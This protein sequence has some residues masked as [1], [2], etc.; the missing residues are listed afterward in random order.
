[1]IELSPQP[2]GLDSAATSKSASE[3]LTYALAHLHAGFRC[4]PDGRL[5]DHGSAYVP[6]LPVERLGDPDFRHALGL[7]ANYVAGAMANGIASVELVEAMR[8][9][10]FLGIFGAAGLPLERIE[11]AISR[12]EGSAASTPFGINL[13]HSPQEPRHEAGVADL[14]L[15]R[16]VT[17][18]EASAYLDLTLPVVRYRL[19][20]IRLDPSGRVTAPNRLIAKVSRVEVASKFMS[21]APPALVRQLVDEGTLSPQQAEWARLLPLAEDLTAEADSAGHTDNRP[22]ITLLP[23]LLALRDRL[24]AKFEYDR[25]IRIGAAGGLGTPA[26]VAAAFTL[27]AAYVVTG[28]VNQACVESGSS[29]AVRSLLAQAEQADTCMA[30]AA[31]MFEM[32]VKVQV[33]KRGTL[34]PM[35]AAK[36]YEL[37]RTH[38][39]LEQIDAAERANLER[40][41]FRASLDDIWSQTEH[42]FRQRD[43]RQL[44][45]AARDGKHKMALVFRWYLGQ[46]SRWANQGEPSR[47]ADYQVWC[48]PAM[49]AFNEW[50]RGSFLEQP[51]QRKVAV[52]AWNLLYGAAVLLRAAMLR[53]QGVHLPAGTPAIR[54]LP[55]AEIRQRLSP[56]GAA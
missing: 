1:M 4:D 46:S 10:G 51:S 26:A 35:R 20:G 42:Y 47:Q 15:R 28:T 25:P 52:V 37:Y 7:R 30:P 5:N 13:I 19:A 56:E 6:P 24:T 23:T 49:G 21:P 31:D 48:G 40:T 17:L 11:D 41:L 45:L 2:A 39:S 18:V 38:E 32:G 14:L 16:R 22:A 3:S 34:F 53:Q 44:E 12:L 29:D 27:G 43:P 8:Q 55:L 50:T 9:A 54:P 33:L 36:L